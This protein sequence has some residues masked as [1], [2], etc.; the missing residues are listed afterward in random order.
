MPMIAASMK[1]SVSIFGLLLLS[2]SVFSAGA[3]EPAA[4]L[5]S[6]IGQLGAAIEWIGVP[7][8]ED[9]RYMIQ[10]SVDGRIFLTPNESFFP[11]LGLIAG[12]EG[13]VDDVNQLNG[14]KSFA[15]IT[16]WNAGDQAEWGVWFEKTGEVEISVWMSGTETGGK[17]ALSLGSDG[18]TAMSTPKS[19]R[20]GEARLVASET[21]SISEAGRKSLILTCDRNE[22]TSAALHWIELAGP[23]VENAAVIRKRWRPAAAHTRFSSS[24]RPDSVRLWI[25]EMDAVPGELDFYS[26]ITTPFGYY[27]PT[28][29][30]DGV[31]N[32]GFNF[33]LWSFGRG[34]AEPPVEQLSHLIAIGD[35]SAKF[36]GFDHEGTGVKI[37]DW[38]PLEGR[39]GQR[40]ALALRV[41][42]GKAYDTY[43]SYFY[44]DDEKRWRLFG[45]G[46]KYN[47]GKPLESLWVGSFVEVPG[48]PPRQRTGAYTRTMR[49]RGWV[50]DDRQKWYPLDQMA[51]ADIDKS[52]GLTYTHR[53]LSGEDSDWFFMQTGGWTFRTPPESGGVEL[54]SGAAKPDVDYLDDEDLD[55]LRT[56]PSEI[57]ATKIERAPGG[58]LARVSFTVRNPGDDAKVTVFYGPEEGLTFVD[59]WAASSEVTQ[60]TEGENQVVLEGVP[61]GQPLKVRL[62]LQNA[63]GQYWSMD[64]L[65]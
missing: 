36:S 41:E 48:P 38:Q 54:L 7:G 30:A 16:Q 52:T 33:S 14:G 57:T 45:V 35:R 21:L 4:T 25:M 44:A 64:T 42:P 29:R 3:V 53:G 20:D 62:L 10:R 23:A 55:F 28:W 27:G 50:M 9:Q 61:G 34:Q 40:Q 51:N 63:E 17:F 24:K 19:A 26:P 43:F 47:R 65:Q 58:D 8:F 18:T 1:I 2:G 37:R 22:A 13:A 5:K 32:T 59:R 60:L 15:N 49:Y 56:V 46:K 39:Q 31:V 12:G 11:K 6:G